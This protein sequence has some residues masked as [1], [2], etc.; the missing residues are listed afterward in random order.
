M[1]SERHS[2]ERLVVCLPEASDQVWRELKE[3]EV[4]L[5]A[6]IAVGATDAVMAR[7]RGVSIGKVRY[8]ARRVMSMTGAANRPHLVS[9]AIAGGVIR[10]TGPQR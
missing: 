8:Q 10:V 5:V 6:Q 7:E 2:R 3:A 1:P 4:E 9:M